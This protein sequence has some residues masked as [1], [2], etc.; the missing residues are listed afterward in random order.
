MTYAIPLYWAGR[1]LVN[2]KVTPGTINALTGVFTPGTI[3]DIAAAPKYVDYVRINMSV[4]QEEISA[5]NAIMENYVQIKDTFDVEICEI[6]HSDGQA[7]LLNAWIGFDV[8]RVQVYTSPDGGTTQGLV[9]CIAVRSGLSDEF[10]EG[11]AV[12]VL[13][14]KPCGLPVAYTPATS[15]T[16]TPV[17]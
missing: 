7:K 10:V 16:I 14:G 2:A 3:Y 17:Y 1:Y 4:R 12:M 9:E 8:F 6:K 5:A 15:G 13:S 11:K